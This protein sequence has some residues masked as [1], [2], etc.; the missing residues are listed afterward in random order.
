MHS[1]YL[2][3]VKRTIGV[4]FYSESRHLGCYVGTPRNRS[5][6]EKRLLIFQ[7]S[8]N[9]KSFKELSFWKAIDFKYFILYDFLPVFQGLK[10]Y[11]VAH[12]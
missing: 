2:G 3:L 4:F 12:S 10:K 1:V 9:L 8:L 5:K 11:L 6:I 7:K